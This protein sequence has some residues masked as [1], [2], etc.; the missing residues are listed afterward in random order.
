MKVKKSEI[1]LWIILFLSASFFYIIDEDAAFFGISYGDIA[2]VILLIWSLYWIWAGF[3]TT[4]KP[5]FYSLPWFISCWLLVLTSAY[6]GAKLYGQSF[7]VGIRAQRAILIYSLLYF[8]VRIYCRKKKINSN[9]FRSILYKTSVVQLVLYTTQYF[10]AGRMHFLHVT[11]A[12]Q[13]RGLRIYYLPVMLDLLFILALDN[14]VKQ[15]GNKKITAI[16]IAGLV[17]FETMV[18]QKF[19]MTSLGLMIIALIF[20]L[21]I[22]GQGNRKTVYILTGAIA[23]G[24]LLNTD[25]VQGII[26]AI[27]GGKDINVNIRAQGR[28]YYLSYLFRYPLLAGGYP[29]SSSAAAVQA[30]GRLQ[31]MQ[32]V[33]NGL[34]GLL[35]MYGGL[36]ALW[37]ISFWAKQVKYGWELRRKTNEL[38]FLLFPVFFL[39]TGL[40]EAHWY[41]NFGFAALAFFNVYQ[42]MTVQEVRARE[43]D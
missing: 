37:F 7:V 6:Q 5:K 9:V 42:D 16:V 13:A 31:H 30:S 38:V 19:R 18:V 36:G 23:L 11:I 43:N 24:I 29:H 12:Y 27:S 3:R 32:L 17:L 15:K 33:D 22:R 34:F 14:L 25:F 41:W 10:L 26:D 35:F 21:L 8:S 40:S 1:V 28:I 4:S 2:L 20:F 39:V